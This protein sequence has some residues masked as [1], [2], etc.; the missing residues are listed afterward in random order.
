MSD[1]RIMTRTAPLSARL[2]SSSS[3]SSPQEQNAK[4]SKAEILQVKRKAIS[5]LTTAYKADSDEQVDE[6]EAQLKDLLHLIRPQDNVP[7]AATTK[8]PSDNASACSSSSSSTRKITTRPISPPSPPA[9][10]GVLLRDF[11]GR[12]PKEGAA[13]PLQC[14]VGEIEK[15]MKQFHAQTATITN[16]PYK[17]MI[18]KEG[19]VAGMQQEMFLE[20]AMG[21]QR[22]E[23][24]N[25]GWLG[26]LLFGTSYEDD[27][28][29]EDASETSGLKEFGEMGGKGLRNNHKKT[30]LADGK[31]RAAK[32]R[33]RSGKNSYAA[34]VSQDFS[35]MIV[36]TT[37][38]SK[39]SNN[40][41]SSSNKS[42][43]SQTSS[44]SSTSSFDSEDDVSTLGTE[45]TYESRSS[46]SERMNNNTGFLQ[47]KR[48]P[49]TAE[50][51]D[52]A[53][54]EG[55]GVVLQ[56]IAEEETASVPVETPLWRW[57]QP[58]TG[59]QVPAAPAQ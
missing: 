29:E 1:P 16:E 30:N 24:E 51:E 8:T 12:K 5:L 9:A 14:H 7:A 38:S 33:S 18:P 20:A 41:G 22:L 40:N 6:L 44:I 21:R 37:T 13:D 59:G 3:S 31:N 28:D 4:K 48:L 54:P 36:T 47:V 45:P 57:F 15:P 42:T 43:I 17:M 23:R 52:E 49:T 34:G 55:E 35:G 46:V 2:A 19:M 50:E 25:G 10:P 32:K 58:R 56:D 53:A 26:F 27:D 11:N 39:K